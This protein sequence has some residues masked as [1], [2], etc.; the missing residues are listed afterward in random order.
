MIN[1]PALPPMFGA[2]PAPDQYSN[3]LL[4]EIKYCCSRA[5]RH[6]L[7]AIHAAFGVLLVAK[8][9]KFRLTRGYDKRAGNQ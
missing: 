8:K 3:D 4:P 9:F 7:K 1:Q 5:G 6:C 2:R